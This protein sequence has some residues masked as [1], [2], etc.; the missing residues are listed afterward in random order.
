MLLSL[1]ACDDSD[2]GGSSSTDKSKYVW[3]LVDTEDYE[4]EEYYEDTEGHEFI[5]SFNYEH[6]SYE[7]KKVYDGETRI[8]ADEEYIHGETYKARCDFNIPP[9]KFAPG[10]QITLDINFRETE[11]TLVGWSGLASFWAAI[12]TEDVIFTGT[13][14]EDI[15]FKDDTGD[16]GHLLNTSE[17]IS[18]I[19]TKLTAEAPKGKKGDR[20]VIRTQIVLDAAS[21]GTRYIYELQKP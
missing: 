3:V 2:D 11:N 19:N 7:V 21:I 20:I 18:S 1:T 14:S 5:H 15:K 9:E 4:R 13:S 10:E 16:Y 8:N 6:G 17:G 12:T